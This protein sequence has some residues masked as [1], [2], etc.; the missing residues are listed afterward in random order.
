[1]IDMKHN[2]FGILSLILLNSS[3]SPDSYFNLFIFYFFN[4]TLFFYEYII[5]FF[6]AP[7]YR[8]LQAIK[9]LN[10]SIK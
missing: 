5:R 2:Y 7:T 1:M 6:L 3:D 4:P 8:V 9:I 10:L